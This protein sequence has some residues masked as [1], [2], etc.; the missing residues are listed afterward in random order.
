ML[1]IGGIVYELKKPTAGFT[2]RLTG[3]YHLDDSFAVYFIASQIDE[4]T[5]LI[6]DNH[7]SQISMFDIEG[8]FAHVTDNTYALSGSTNP[9]LQDQT[10]SPEK[11]KFD[12]AVG[13]DIWSFTKMSETPIYIE[14]AHLTN[15]FVGTYLDQNEPFRQIV[16]DDEQTFYFSDFNEGFYTK[17]VFEKTADNAYTLSGSKLEEQTIVCEDLTITLVIDGTPHTF[18]KALEE[19]YHPAGY[20]EY[21]FGN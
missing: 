10:I 8:S 4:S 6:T 15:A 9:L 19:A 18:Q 17:G 20:D 16:V 21:E 13:E 12:L 1:A 3:T 5:F 2:N 7:W 14:H 11:F